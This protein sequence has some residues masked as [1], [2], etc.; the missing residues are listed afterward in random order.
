MDLQNNSTI[1]ELMSVNP[2]SVRTWLTSKELSG[3]RETLQA[4]LASFPKEQMYDE[5]YVDLYRWQLYLSDRWVSRS[6]ALSSLSGLSQRPSEITR[7]SQLK[8]QDF[9]LNLSYEQA[10]GLRNELDNIKRMAI[11]NDGDPAYDLLIKSIVML[12]SVFVYK[13][14]ASPWDK[15]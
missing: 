8:N 3:L 11:P 12:K 2:D 9:L 4:Y 10:V 5:A 13:M 15:L 1:H 7:L 6:T 14:W